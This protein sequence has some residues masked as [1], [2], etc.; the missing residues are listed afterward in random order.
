MNPEYQSTN[1]FQKILMQFK[2]A[3]CS[4]QNYL[5]QGMFYCLQMR[6]A[7]YMENDPKEKKALK[8][9]SFSFFAE[10]LPKI[11]FANGRYADRDRS[12]ALDISVLFCAISV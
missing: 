6:C 3:I 2:E 1:L 9:T 5:Q 7:F 10:I 12:R 4:A 8:C 11:C